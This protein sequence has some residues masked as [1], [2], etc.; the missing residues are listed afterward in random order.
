MIAHEVKLRVIRPTRGPETM[1]A[2]YLGAL[3]CSKSAKQNK[4]LA[5]SFPKT[6]RYP[7]YSIDQ[8]LISLHVES[9]PVAAGGRLWNISEGGAAIFVPAELEIG[10]NAEIQ[11]RLAAD[12][13]VLRLRA[14]LRNRVGFRCGFEFVGLNSRERNQIARACEVLELQE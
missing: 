8:R 4:I 6:R 1:P 14:V 7:R 2:G 12:A 5:T 13:E 11:F 3:T 9:N 10:T